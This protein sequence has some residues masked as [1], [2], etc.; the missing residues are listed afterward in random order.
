MLVPFN[1]RRTDLNPDAGR[2]PARIQADG[3]GCVLPI[4]VGHRTLFMRKHV[5][6]SC[7]MFNAAS[8]I[9]MW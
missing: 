6:V 5:A 3:V 8:S 2:K 4:D 9:L 7:G 1:V